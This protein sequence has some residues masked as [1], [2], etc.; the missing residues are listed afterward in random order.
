M[1]EALGG[2]LQEA[3]VEHVRLWGRSR[4]FSRRGLH[5]LMN[6]R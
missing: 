1:N 4:K 3:A 5:G 6:L 2:L